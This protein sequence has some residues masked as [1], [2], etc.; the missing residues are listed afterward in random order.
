MPE[1]SV[2]LAH[3]CLH[4]GWVMP[5]AFSLLT[6]VCTKDSTWHLWWSGV[7]CRIFH[8]LALTTT[9]VHSNLMSIYDWEKSN[10][11]RVSWTWMCQ[12]KLYGW[13]VYSSRFST[14]SYKNHIVN[15][16]TCVHP[17][18]PKVSSVWPTLN[19]GSEAKSSNMSWPVY[20]GGTNSFVL[21]PRC[22]LTGML[23]I[24]LLIKLHVHDKIGSNVN[25]LSIILFNILVNSLHSQSTNCTH[26]QT[27]TTLE[28]FLVCSMSSDGFFYYWNVW[29]AA[30]FLMFHIHVF[31]RQVIGWFGDKHDCQQEFEGCASCRR[32]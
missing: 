16:G 13:S 9:V 22:V 27:Q 30:A 26:F 11:G 19:P 24:W 12:I 17:L 29:N 15:F 23:A 6:F 2:S 28:A 3:H 21:G 10:L 4:A 14:T 32:G 20:I 1:S 5:L 8:H 31:V 25:L 18:M 7:L